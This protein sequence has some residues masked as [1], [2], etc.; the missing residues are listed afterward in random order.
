M[1]NFNHEQNCLRLFPTVLSISLSLSSFYSICS[2]L[3]I[4]GH[5]EEKQIWINLI[6]KFK[7]CNDKNKIKKKLTISFKWTISGY[8][9][10]KYFIMNLLSKSTALCSSPLPP[11]SLAVANRFIMCCLISCRF[12]VSMET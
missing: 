10:R 2:P 1:T 8:S 9:L 6:C 5:E 3:E 4:K 11:L 7:Y 12:P